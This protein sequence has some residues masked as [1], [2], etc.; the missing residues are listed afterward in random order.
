ML[1]C[2]FYLS[3]I[4]VELGIAGLDLKEDDFL[5][6]S[7]IESVK[8]DVVDAFPDEGEVFWGVGKAGED[9]GEGF[10]DLSDDD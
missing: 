10:T 1:D 7:C 9:G 6:L 4:A 2:I 5:D 8:D 3:F